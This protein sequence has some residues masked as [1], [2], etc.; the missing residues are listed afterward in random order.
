MRIVVFAYDKY[1]WL[2]PIFMHFYKKNWPDNPYRT[3]HVITGEFPWADHAL[4]YINTLGDEPFL[5]ILNDY[6]IEKPVDIAIVRRAEKLCMGDVG[7]VRL[8]PH[9]KE[10]VYLVS[11][12]I[13]GFKEYPLNKPY[14]VSL[15]T[16]IWQKKFF[17]EFLRKGESIW[18]TETEGSKRVLNSKKRVMWSDVPAMQYS[19]QGYMKKGKVVKSVEQWT[20]ENW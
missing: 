6:I 17:L 16:S 5:L 14:A 2:T 1:D 13:D 9:D 8:V 10:A 19:T 12:G 4:N 7:C 15:Q 3:D 20:K 18:Q 11:A